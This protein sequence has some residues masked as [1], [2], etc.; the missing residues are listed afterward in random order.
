VPTTVRPGAWLIAAAKH[1][2]IDLG[3]RRS[4]L[5]RKHSELGRE[6]EEKQENS[7]PDYASALDDDIGD[8]LLRLIF[9]SCHPVLST[10]AQLAL[11]LRLIG[12]LTTNEIARAFL[13]PEPAHRSR[14]TH[15]RRC[16][17]ALR[18]SARR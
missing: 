4:L 6:L 18:S 2:A 15:T 3:R 8:D 5:D 17:R 13:V 9:T 1:R 11:T 14:H 16:T 12:G 10:E 7:V